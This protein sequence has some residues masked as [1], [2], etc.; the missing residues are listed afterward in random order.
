[1]IAESEATDPDP[2]ETMWRGH[3]LTGTAERSVRVA[4]SIAIDYELHPMPAGVL[5]LGLV[6]DPGTAASAAMNTRDAAGQSSLTELIQEDWLGTELGGLDLTT[7]WHAAGGPSGGPRKAPARRGGQRIDRLRHPAYRG[8]LAAAVLLLFA[9]LV[10]GGVLTAPATDR[11]GPP[12]HLVMLTD[13]AI[14]A[15]YEAQPRQSRASMPLQNWRGTGRKAC[16]MSERRWTHTDGRRQ[17]L[18]KVVRCESFVVAAN[19][20]SLLEESVARDATSTTVTDE[21]P[22]SLLAKGTESGG[23]KL[24]YTAVIFRRGQYLVHVRTAAP[25]ESSSPGNDR[26]VRDVAQRQWRAVPGTPGVPL[27]VFDVYTD[28]TGV[29]REALGLATAFLAFLNILAWFRVRA[30]R[31]TARSRPPSDSTGLRWIDV[32]A[33]ARTLEVDAQRRFWG[34]LLLWTALMA[35]PLPWWILL[36][37]YVFVAR[38]L[39]LTQR[40]LPGTHKIWGAHSASQVNTGRRPFSTASL[41]VASHIAQ[42]TALAGMI[43]IPIFRL[44][45]EIGYIMPNG[46]FHPAVVADSG[47]SLPLRLV[48]VPLLTVGTLLLILG[49]GLL[50]GLLYRLARGWAR[51]EAPVLRKTD[52]RPPVLYLRNFADDSLTIRTSPLTRPTILEKLGVRQFENFEELIHRYLS[53]YGPV[54]TIK[55]PDARWQ[56]LGVAREDPTRETWQAVVRRNIAE[57]GLIVVGATPNASTAGLGWELDAI[58]AAGALDR[59]IFLLAPRPADTV[60]W[61]WWRFRGMAFFR[62]PEPIDFFADR[63]L[64]ARWTGAGGWTAVHAA[65]R[66]D[67]AYALAM[68]RLAGEILDMPDQSQPTAEH[69]APQPQ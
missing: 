53:V 64:A 11:P 9:G 31:L 68:S 38:Q 3:R 12:P 15:E 55:D 28:T 30:R 13:D 4:M 5:A 67:W 46:R 20:H 54:T 45:Q 65:K 37:G 69:K 48:P 39:V 8:M 21:I 36:I 51:L 40:F 18:I 41:V 23:S 17:A 32:G 61:H 56:P 22:Y 49:I 42:V 63:T 1:M 52:R 29:M 25:G 57:S 60:G 26:S 16:A 6:A 44:L 62:I 10:V 2:A 43:I 7:R 59:T 66:T 24:S 47:W 50:W 33:K 19:L 58:I 34:F 35:F 14:G 27:P